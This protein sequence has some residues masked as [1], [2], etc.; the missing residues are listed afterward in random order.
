MD[1]MSCHCCS[2]SSGVSDCG[3]GLCRVIPCD[4]EGASSVEGLSWEVDPV[5][6]N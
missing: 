3:R 5:A 2:R 4:V 6:W 1:I